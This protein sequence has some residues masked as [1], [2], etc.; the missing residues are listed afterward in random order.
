MSETLPYLTSLFERRFLPRS[1]P[2]YLR[3]LPHIGSIA[4]FVE[5]DESRALCLSQAG[6]KLELIFTIPA[7]SPGH[8]WRYRLPLDV[9]QFEGF[10][11]RAGPDLHRLTYYPPDLPWCFDC[12]L[13]GL[14]GLVLV[15]CWFSSEA[16]MERFVPPDFVLKE[17]TQDP[18]FSDGMLAGK[19]YTELGERLQ[20]YDFRP[21]Y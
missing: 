3:R 13:G 6:S 12:F 2:E 10:C 5:G 8:M 4:T 1:V 7:S 17:V 14:K 9:D 11:S 20:Q 21:F 15:R 19:S 18:L 16:E